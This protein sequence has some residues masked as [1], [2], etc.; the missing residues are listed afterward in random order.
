MKSSTA[1]F[2]SFLFCIISIKTH[3]QCMMIPVSLNERVTKSEFIVEGTVAEKESFLDATSGS[4]YTINKIEIK[5]W[6]KSKQKS[7]YIY[8]RTEGG[9][10]NN[11]ATKVFPSLQLNPNTTYVLF[12]TK[13]GADK[14]NR[15]LRLRNAAIT[16][17]V[18]YAGAQGGIIESLGLF[19]DIMEHQQQTEADLLQKIKTITGQDAVTPAGTSYKATPYLR[20]ANHTLA[21]T[22]VAPTTVRSG[23]T[24]TADQI[25]ITGSGFGT[26]PGSVFFT[27]ADNGGATLVSSGLNSDIINW[28]DN[29]ITVK[30]F[31]TA[32]TGPVNVNGLF[33]SAAPLNVQYAHLALEQ[34][35][36][37]F[38]EPTRQRFYLRN[39]NGSGGYTFQFNT[40]FAAN[41]AAVTAF[42]NAVFSW[43]T[44]TSVNFS[45]TG[46]TSVATAT[47]DGVNAVFFNASLPVG[48]LAIC[49]SNFNGGATLAC[50]Q[51]NT[52]W[53]LTDADISFRDV[54][55]GGT[56]WQF[57][58]GAPT[59]SQFDFQSV[60]LHE[61]GHALGLGHVIAPGQVMHFALANG[62][63][64]RTLSAND[65]AAGIAKV[66]YSDDPTCFNPSGSGT[67]MIPATGGTLPVT[68]GNFN[69]KRN[70][71]SSVQVY[72]NTLQ[73]LN[74]KGFFI[75][76]GETTQQL[77]KIGFVNGKGVS[78]SAVDYMFT[79]HE[80][81]PYPWFYRL[82]QQDFDGRTVS[83]AVVFVEGD[84]TKSWRVWSDENGGTLQV[85]IQQLEQ[86]NIQ[87]Q[88]FH[89]NGQLVLYKAIAANRTVIPVHQLIKGYYNYRLTDG[90]TVISGKLLIGN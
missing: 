66:G 78:F 50:T 16:Q 62:A 79:D 52:V 70:T 51:Q 73:E 34:S 6:L 35:F 56:T 11:H 63:T 17:T 89:A 80:A 25:T 82:T 76:R 9:V 26:T 32:G 58:P 57:G 46:T 71:K 48:T 54:P 65:I 30:V 45:A 37:G 64:A 67:P 1:S 59:G 88:L 55:T 4:V 27:N 74:N 21:I 69:A 14:E 61:L 44:N 5:A 40:A 47:N 28:S 31:T 68:L 22:S 24:E 60:A 75:E 41:T 8:I 86:K 87:L 2:L 10:Y 83:S 43:R 72:W 39:L 29:S 3:S 20:P 33:T 12:L 38:A 42:S 19:T 13:A 15:N 81:G 49:T 23:T 53:W 77:K 90:T 85:Y 18:P 84:K 36:F 7:K